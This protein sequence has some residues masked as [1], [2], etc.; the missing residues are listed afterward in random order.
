MLKVFAWL[1]SVI[2]AFNLGAGVKSDKPADS[3]LE[4]KI[5]DH[6]D[7]IVDETAA[8]VDDVTD[9]LRKNEKVQ[10]AEE[11]VGDVKEIIDNTK[12]DIDAHFG[13]TET[14]ETTEEAVEA[15]TAAEDETTQTEAAEPE[16]T[17]E[18]VE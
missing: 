17:A 16:V 18:P 1:F 4:Q 7:V 3:E 10:K 14:T 13:T 12:N 6:M 2:F 5:R 15:E 9:E 11:F 8:M